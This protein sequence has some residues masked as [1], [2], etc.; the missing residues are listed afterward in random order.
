MSRGDQDAEIPGSGH[1]RREGMLG[2]SAAAVGLVKLIRMLREEQAQQQ[3]CMLDTMQ[4]LVE[5][6]RGYDEHR[7]QRQH[8]HV[9]DQIRLARLT[10]A[11]DIESYLTMFERMMQMGDIVEETWTLRLV[12]QLAFAAIST[13]DVAVYYNVKET[14]LRR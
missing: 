12:P 3:R 13:E 10:K 6:S 2:N 7:E 8:V 5:C 11:D 9:T 4:C 1:I 14:I